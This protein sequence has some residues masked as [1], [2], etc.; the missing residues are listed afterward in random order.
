MTILIGMA[1]AEPTL[2]KEQIIKLRDVILKAENEKYRNVFDVVPAYDEKKQS[3]WFS[4]GGY[5]ID[6]PAYHLEIR[7]KDGYYRLGWVSPRGSSA[8]Y[9]RFRMSPNIK[10]QVET[11]LDEFKQP[12]KK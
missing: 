5:G 2:S 9:D 12:K 10:R 4:A 8:G 1:I 11:L 6:Q 7:E 3:W